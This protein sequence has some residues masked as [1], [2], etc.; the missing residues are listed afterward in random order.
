MADCPCGSG[1]AFDA[2]CAPFLSGDA[3]PETAEQ[4]L[5]SRYTAFTRKNTDYVLNTTHPDQVKKLDIEAVAAWAEN[6]TWKALEIYRVDKGAKGDDEAWIDFI[7]RYDEEGEEIEHSERAHFVKHEG[8]WV[9]DHQRSGTPQLQAATKVG[10]ND[11]CPCGTG[12]K[13]KKCCG[14]AA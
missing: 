1:S 2:C 14:K 8:R 5:R 12:K 13:F 10:R 11:P 3:V 9:F 4:L 7:A 6:A